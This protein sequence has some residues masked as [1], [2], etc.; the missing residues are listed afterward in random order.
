MKRLKSVINL[1]LFLGI[2]SHCAYKEVVL[3]PDYREVLYRGWQGRP[4]KGKVFFQGEILFL[5]NEFLSG[6]SYGTF[7]VLPSALLL[8]LQPPLSPQILIFWQKEEEEIRFLDT[9]KRKYYKI[10]LKELKNLDLSFYFLG[11]KE[12][13]FTF[14]KDFWEGEYKFHRESLEGILESNVFRIQWK[15]KEITFSDEPWGLPNWREYKE[16]ELKLPNL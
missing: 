1:F 10:R 8:V 6:G 13:S 3:P 14:K 4:L 15:I 9:S 12:T 11:L 7:F 16:K 2:L 5:K